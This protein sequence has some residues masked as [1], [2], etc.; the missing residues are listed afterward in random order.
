[1]STFEGVCFYSV[2]RY[3]ADP[4]RN[5][6]RNIGVVVVDSDTGEADGR[7]M[8]SRAYVPPTGELY[9]LV[10][11]VV[12]S[13]H[14][15]QTGQDTL[16]ELSRPLVT[17]ELLGELHSTSTNTIQFTAPLPSPGRLADVR[18]EVFHIFVAPK[19]GG[20]SGGWSTS[21]ATE[22]FARRFRRADPALEKFVVPHPEINV[23][24][25]PPFIF[26]LG[27]GNGTWHTIIENASLGNKD[28]QIPE[29][30]AAWMGMAW[31]A[32]RS[33]TSARAL[34]FVEQAAGQSARY[35]RIAQWMERFGVE[36]LPSDRA[37]G[38][39]EQLARELILHKA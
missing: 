21:V 1:M 14:L 2:V 9:S 12:G 26:D 7:F 18:D 32:V 27:I 13:L 38:V 23:S 10:R 17:T 20:S 22:V 5:E 31:E 30:R 36:V 28:L 37:D 11:R 15:P 29:Q 16:F 19:H 6:P 34:L 35:D 8:L 25:G 39:A 24:G 3:V 33:E 4:I